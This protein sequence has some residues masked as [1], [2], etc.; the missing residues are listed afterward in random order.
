[1]RLEKV[2]VNLYRNVVDS[3]QFPIEVDVT[4]LVGK[5]ESGKTAILHALCS[6]NPAFPESIRVDI[7]HDY[8]RWRK[9]RDNRTKDLTTVA[10]ITAV[11]SLEATDIKSISEHVQFDLPQDI[12]IN[13][14]RNYAGELLISFVIDESK[15]LE[16]LIVSFDFDERQKKEAMS[17][18]SFKDFIDFLQIEYQKQEDKRKTSAK[19][20]SE[21]I[22]V[23]EKVIKFTNSVSSEVLQ[24]TEKLL[25]KFFYFSEYSSLPGRLDLHDLLNKKQGFSESERTALSFLKLAGVEGNELMKGDFEERIAEL[26]AAANEITNQV[27]EYWTQSEDL[28]VTLVGDSETVRINNAQ[29]VVHRFVDIRL[30]DLR[31]QMTTNFETRSSGFQWFFSFITAFSEFS[32]DESVIILLDEPGLG[33]HARAQQDLLKFIDERLAKNNQVVYT[34]HS[35]FMVNPKKLER[36]RL[37]EDL[38]TRKNPDRGTQVSTDTLSVHGDTLF[39]LQAALGYD[40][41]QNLF[42]GGYNLIVEGPSDLIFLL[43]LSEYLEDSG[44]ESLDERFTIVPVGGIDKI[45]TFIAL[46]GAKLNVTVLIDSSSA[47]NQRIRDMIHRGLLASGKLIGVDSLTDKSPSD[48]EDLFLESEYLK[49]FNDAFGLDVKES[50]LQG[51]DSIIRKLERYRGE[52]FE[53]LKPATAFLKVKEEFMSD[54]SEETLGKFEKL[55]SVLNGTIS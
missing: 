33:L 53:H 24:V 1:M 11:F 51:D 50:D 37:V 21:I 3:N 10:P 54:L 47:P 6:L 44:R 13:A 55:F 12:T 43:T 39:P 45:P 38:T 19:S 5:N 36:A 23:V 28:I 25:P 30:N 16:E 22:D 52:K 27:F 42:V 46:L 26:E 8:P 4:C 32:E 2:Q 20:L 41:A 7:T 34:T 48:I 31:H 40:L 35:P 17:C 15:W 18:E 9:V 49:I 29:S 14:G